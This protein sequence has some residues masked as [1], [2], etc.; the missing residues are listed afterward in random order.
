[1]SPLNGQ[2]A[3]SAANSSRCS[4][5]S[6]RSKLLNLIIENPLPRSSY[7][8]TKWRSVGPDSRCGVGPSTAAD[9]ADY[10]Y[11][12]AYLF[13]AKT[14]AFLSTCQK[15]MQ[16]R[17]TSGLLRLVK[18]KRKKKKLI[19]AHPLPYRTIKLSIIL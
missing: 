3:S 4:A 5:M 10:L 15:W 8:L 7:S 13:E 16:M 18:K 6:A 2:I 14:T 11:A 1:M 19:T 9:S 17:P 12:T